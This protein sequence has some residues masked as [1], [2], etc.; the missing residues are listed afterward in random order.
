M[1]PDDMATIYAAAFPNSRPW[2]SAEI[3]DILASPLSFSVTSDVGFALGRVILDE[4]ELLTIAVQPDH[5]GCG[6]GQRLL[7]DFEIE[8]IRRGASLCFLEVAQDNLVALALYDACGYEFCG[9]RPGYY[10]KS[11]GTQ[12]AASLM[13]KALN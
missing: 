9:E 2:S 8:S 1:T 4:V 13:K 5:Q 11:D 7:A 6:K 10:S 12:I 3:S